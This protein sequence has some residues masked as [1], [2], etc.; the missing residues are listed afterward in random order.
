MVF[1]GGRQRQPIPPA[2]AAGFHP[3]VAAIPCHGH[4]ALARKGQEFHC[5]ETVNAS[6]LLNS[7]HDA[8][9][10]QILRVASTFVLARI[11]ISVAWSPEVP[12]SV[13]FQDSFQDS[14]GATILASI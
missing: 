3:Y 4:A 1:C 11:K 14:G 7:N 2:G 9:L 13:M 12:S 10:S 6:P 8:P 5:V